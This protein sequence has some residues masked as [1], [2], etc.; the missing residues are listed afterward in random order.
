MRLQRIKSEHTCLLAQHR[1]WK[2]SSNSEK[3]ILWLERARRNPVMTRVLSWT[4]LALPVLYV[5]S[6]LSFL[7]SWSFGNS[8]RLICTPSCVIM[9]LYFRC[10][11]HMPCFKICIYQPRVYVHYLFAIGLLMF[12]IPF[13]VELL[14]WS[15]YYNNSTFSTILYYTILYY[16]ILYYTILYYTILLY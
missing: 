2:V 10:T 14:N 13:N 5:I 9:A 11:C 1:L 4:N 3:L 15:K 8:C 12:I 6:R 16:T 7:V